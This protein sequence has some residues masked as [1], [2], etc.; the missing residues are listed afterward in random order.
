M[1]R[2][3]AAAFVLGVMMPALSAEPAAS[4]GILP[5][6]DYSGDLL[7]RRFLT[8]DWGGA[9]A[10]LAD[11]GVQLNLDFTQTMQS[12]VDGGRDTGTRYGGSL[13][14]SISADLMR[15]GVMPGALLNFRAESRFG[16]SA[17]DIAGPALPVNTNAFFPMTDEL[18][19][20]IPFTITTLSY[21]QMFS[22]NIGITLGKF[23]TLDG[24]PNEFAGGR[25]VSQFMNA[26]FIFNPSAMLLV[27]YSTLGGGVVLMPTKNIFISSLVFTTADSSTTTGFKNI[28]DGWTWATEGRFQYRLGD[29]PGGVN[30]GFVYGFDNHF[31]ELGT[32]R[33]A[34]SRRDGFSIKN[35]TEQDTWAA[36]G[37]F[38][39]YLINQ[40]PDDKPVDV[41]DGRPDHRGVG[42][43]ARI[44]IADD[45][46][47]PIDFYVG[48][49]VGGRGVIPCR[50]EDAFG[51][52][53]YYTEIKSNRLTSAVGIEDH[54]NGFEAFYNIAI[55]PA[56]HFTLDAQVVESIFESVDTATILGARFNVR[57]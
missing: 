8:G 21:L 13:D 6:P 35:D 48:A 50:P 16:E 27:P 51:L 12:V 29:L 56:C 24:D 47:N 19:R 11:K 40:D 1:Q 25:G 26:N 32:G 18:D 22:E 20:D 55:T 44:G 17:D 45:D 9:R 15:M 36:Y 14:Y 42:L 39:Q 10:D 46:T 38:W 34:F 43:F 23:D 54:A 3:I 28:G 37:T 31:A 30:V 7:S 2:L 53:Y 4:Q 5:A 33:L 49:G 52:G 57:F 41:S